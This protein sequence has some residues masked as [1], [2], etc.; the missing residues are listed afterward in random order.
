MT[1]IIIGSDVC[2]YNS[3]EG[4]DKNILGGVSPS[5][6]NTN[7]VI[8]NLE[9]PLTDSE[10]KLEKTGPCLRASKEIA[11]Q[12]KDAGITACTMANNHIMDFGSEGLVDS[13]TACYKAGL[14]V[15]G[16]GETLKDAQQPIILNLQG[17]QLG[18]IACAENEWSIAGRN[19]PGANPLDMPDLLE[20]ISI[21]K[22]KVNGLIITIHGGREHYPLPY[23]K[24]QHWC[25]HLI[26]AG[27]NAVICQHSHCPGTYE[28]YQSGFI[29]YGQG[30]LVFPPLRKGMPKSWFEGYLLR[31]SFKKSK[32]LKWEIIPYTL[33]H[34][35]GYPT[36]MNPS[37]ACLMKENL[38]K[39][40]EILFDPEKLE[41]EW[42][43]IVKSDEGVFLSVLAGGNRY[44]RAIN[45]RWPIFRW[46]YSAPKR[47]L[48]LNMM[49]CEAI[50]EA[51]LSLLK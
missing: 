13:I 16:V 29:S 51:Y 33:N 26:R 36:L 49:R 12:L 40:Q 17:F 47:K 19:S 3:F 41:K 35:S 7:A 43:N 32:P 42:D 27:A 11:L 34:I 20:Q 24:L 50:R 21:L 45:R 14:L 25:R 22:P 2:P 30:N 23:P 15:T 18:L 28:E 8:V 38:K 31:F 6:K 9:C 10:L 5:F 39:Q 46:W 1:S 44:I 4:Q 37:K 48:L